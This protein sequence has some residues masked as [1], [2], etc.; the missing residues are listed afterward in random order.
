M[1]DDPQHPQDV[2]ER[3]SAARIRLNRMEAFAER[4]SVVEELL[5]LGHAAQALL[6][7]IILKVRELPRSRMAKL[8]ATLKSEP[9]LRAV[10]NASIKL[11][12]DE[13]VLL[14]RAGF[15]EFEQL[16]VDYLWSHR[17]SESLPYCSSVCDALGDCAR[18]QE[19]L[20]ALSAL[21]R[22][23]GPR[24]TQIRAK[25]EEEH[26]RI[27]LGEMTP[28]D[29]WEKRSDENLFLSAHEY[30][31]KTV[32]KLRKRPLVEEIKTDQ[33]A[34]TIGPIDKPG[35]ILDLLSKNESDQLEFKSTLR[36]D[37]KTSSLNLKL[38]GAILKTVAAFTNANGGN[39]LIGVSDNGQVLGLDLDYDSLADAKHGIVGNADKF[40]LHLGILLKNT[41]GH[42]FA[43]NKVTTTIHKIGNKEICL[44]E[45]QRSK[46]PIVIDVDDGKG[47][48]TQTCFVRMGNA[49]EPIT[50]EELIKHMEDRH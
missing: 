10:Q 11:F 18:L 36:W 19:T 27:E 5:S 35:D 12:T 37:L 20:T 14:L 41:F 33:Q 28:M 2:E 15:S 40:K 45:V 34:L 48:K 9:L 44:V 21:E 3:I 29:I 46:R 31:L 49:S 47:R 1:K 38:E 50:L 8:I 7:D 32:E 39:L 6:P 22:H 30:L 16:L 17:N 4:G 26:K 23:F 25:H 42:A 24:A 13:Q 43:T